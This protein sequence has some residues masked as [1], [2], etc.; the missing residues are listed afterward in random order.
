[1]VFACLAICWAGISEPSAA[2]G[3]PNILLIVADDMGYSDIGS[4][5]GEIATPT[6][7]RLAAGGIRFSSFHVLPTCAPTRAVLLAGTDNHTAGLGSQAVNATQQGKPG[8]EGYLSQRVAVL[9]EI[10]GNAGYRTYHSGKWHLG[11][12]ESQGP[13]ARG[14]RESFALLPG[15]ASHFADAI[16]LHPGEPA[17]YRRNGDIIESLPPD[18]YSTR[19][20]TDLMLSW[21]ERDKQSDQPFFAY[22]AYTAPHDPLHAPAAAIEKYRGTYDDGYEVLRE[23]RFRGL[24]AAGIIPDHHALPPWPS[25]VPRWQDLP[26]REQANKARDMEVYAAMIDI[27]DEQIGRI[28]QW[29]EEN[30]ELENTLVVFFSDNGANGFPPSLYPEHDAE[31]HSQFDDRLENRGAPGS[32]VEMGAGWATASTA[33]FRLFKGFSTEGGIRTP[34]IIKLPLENPA[35][36]IET[37]FVHVR[38]LLPT[39]LEYAEVPHPAGQDPE[40]AQPEGQSLLPLLSGRADYRR[41][42]AGIGY[43]LHGTRAYIKGDWKA[44][45]MPVPMG[46]GE[47]ELFNL[48]EDPGELNN[49]ARQES[50]RLSELVLEHQDYEASHGVIYGLPGVLARINQVKSLL[51]VALW[52]ILLGFA[53]SVFFGHRKTSYALVF[54]GI[55]VGSLVYYMKSGLSLA[56]LL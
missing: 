37:S 10:L 48:R 24:Q 22:L 31:F 13:H 39:F 9:P 30:G 25:V 15:G 52:V 33:A 54:S 56:L 8:Y 29:L 47:W 6:L 23:K 12:G 40:L 28:I 49:L 51:V 46:S 44:L 42:A 11:T 36:R 45:Q 17:A 18:F 53:C 35:P 32:F 7:D 50:E 21:M 55:I 3:R 5:G 26:A 14:F 27:M 2:S 41:N 1:V 19:Y 4:F 43:E 34:A 38:D 16:P 20:Y